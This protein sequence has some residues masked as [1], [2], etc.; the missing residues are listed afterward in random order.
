MI[1]AK[2]RNSNNGTV[3]ILTVPKGSNI[4][5]GDYVQLIKVE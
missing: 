3:K 5:K 4:E 2:V 1:I